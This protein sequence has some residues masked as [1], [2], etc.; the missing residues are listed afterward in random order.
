M[1]TS[2]IEFQR[3][4]CN[5]TV[6]R[7]LDLTIHITR[8]S[9]RR[10]SNYMPLPS[11]LCSK[12]VIIN[13]NNKDNRCFMLS[14]LAALYPTNIHAARIVKYKDH[15]SSI[16]IEG[17]SFPVKMSD[18][19]RFEKQIK[20]SVNVFGYEKNEVFPIHITRNRYERHINVLMISHHKKSH[21]CWI[22]DLNR[23]LYDQKT[24]KIRYHNHY[25]SFCL[26][27]FTKER[28]LEDHI[29]YCLTHEPQKIEL[30]SEEDIWLYY[31]DIRKQL[32]V[33]YIIYVHF[34]SLLIP[35]EGCENGPDISLT[36]KTAKH[37]PCDL[38]TKSSV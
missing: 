11:R 31:K 25:C 27:G 5:W 2:F 19:Q 29:P 3:P 33:P 35:I 23:L 6:D 4:G 10:G 38:S 17:I 21:F 12:H 34:E 9:P 32:K 14:I 13:V 30:P 8:Y 26:H 7:V 24:Y 1:H 20:L 37:L 16:N 36:I 15:I 28:L 18:I 22:K